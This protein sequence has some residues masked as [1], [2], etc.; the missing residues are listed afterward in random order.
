VPPPPASEDA[1]HRDRV[2]YGRA[3]RL[4]L[5]RLVSCLSILGEV[6]LPATGHAFALDSVFGFVAFA[7]DAHLSPMV[8]KLSYDVCSVA[9]EM[10]GKDAVQAFLASAEYD[11]L[12]VLRPMC[13]KLV[14]G[15][16][17]APPSPAGHGH[18]GGMQ[19]SPSMVN[20]RGMALPPRPNLSVT[21][22]KK[23]QHNSSRLHSQPF[24][25]TPSPI[26]PTPNK[27]HHTSSADGSTYGTHQYDDDGSGG[28]AGMTA[29]SWPMAGG[30]GSAGQKPWSVPAREKPFT[31]MSDIN[32]GIR[33]IGNARGGMHSSGGGSGIRRGRAGSGSGYGVAGNTAGYGMN[34]IMAGARAGAGG[35]GTA[36][37]EWLQTGLPPSTDVGVGV[38][39]R[40]RARQRLQEQQ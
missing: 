12:R 5:G 29:V 19:S 31:P 13:A 24:D 33:G 4:L 14:P 6:N 23:Q 10:A 1:S 2:N 11:A 38:K 36:V 18:G 34:D 27:H 39:G 20:A 15:L 35:S 28:G 8:K 26:R 7:L 40:L 16:A 22:Q 30:V 21:P 3:G 9:C 37:P 32:A 17:D 25:P